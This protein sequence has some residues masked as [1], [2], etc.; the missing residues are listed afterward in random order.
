MN[1][2]WFRMKPR[3]V[4]RTIEWFPSFAALEGENWNSIDENRIS[5]NTKRPVNTIRREYIYTAHREDFDISFDEFLSGQYDNVDVESAARNDKISF[6]FFGF[7]YVDK[8]NIIRVTDV[9]KLIVD[10]KMNEEYLLKQL[11]KIQ[12]PSPI[13]RKKHESG[14]VFAME[15]LLNIYKEFDYL[16]QLEI[17]LLFGCMDINNLGITINA[18]KQFR[19]KYNSLENKSKVSDV[20]KIFSNILYSTYPG[21]ENKPKTYIDYA[22][23][24]IRAITYTGLFLTRGRGIYTKLYIPEHS[25]V[26][27]KLL[28][29]KHEFIYNQEED[30]DLYM[31]YFGNPYNIILPWDN[32]QDRKII[33]ETKLKNYNDIVEKAINVDEELV[34][35]DLP[36]I[37]ELIKTNDY[38]SLIIADEELSDS[39]LSINERIFIHSTSK[40]PEIREEIIEKFEDINEG[41]ED[42]AA[43]WL[44]VNTW[45]SLVAIN[46]EHRVK[47]NFKLEEDLTPR[48][49]AVGVGNTPDM[50][51]YVN[52]YILVPEVSL[53][54]GVKQWEHEG[55]SVIDHVLKFIK[56]YEDKD[57]YGIFISKRMNVRIVWQFFIL[58]RE[59]WVERNVPVIPLT[60]EQYI[61]II[62][63]IYENELDIHDFVS[64]ILSINK[65]ALYV[66]NYRKWEKNIDN[67]IE[68]WKTSLENK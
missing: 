51:V 26:K 62:E 32:P 12:F 47:R 6:E 8:D 53:M 40:T 33:V 23:A 25:K 43:L 18:I 2:W 44:E 35:K 58:N 48:S 56:Q 65:N 19:K 16:T 20:I 36:R 15:V 50:E 38:K 41:N 54:S 3:S 37:K 59:S 24:L 66:S 14:Y 7:G 60:I 30:L 63:F 68:D 61:R 46:G 11:L 31:K 45:K 52:G 22:D 10:K 34:I 1:S 39:L 28:Q 17:A 49:F 55:S 67:I 42:M 29:D 9:G 64:L 27:V 13:V 4:L 5:V 21:I 57:V